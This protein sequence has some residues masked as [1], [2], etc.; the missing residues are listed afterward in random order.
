MTVSGSTQGDC[1]IDNGAYL[2]LLALRATAIMCEHEHP[3]HSWVAANCSMGLKKQKQPYTQSQSN[4]FGNFPGT[5]KMLNRYELQGLLIY[6]W[7]L[8]ISNHERG[9]WGR[10]LCVL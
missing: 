2:E 4:E 9:L 7:V 5:L 10:G 1:V 6:P 8:C 3:S